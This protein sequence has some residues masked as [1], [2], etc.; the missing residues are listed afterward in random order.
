M[1]ARFYVQ[2]YLLTVPVFFLI[3]LVW[4]GLIAS[5]FY[6][7]QLG[8]LLADEVNWAAALVFYFSYIVGILA[9]ATLP[10]LHARSLT[11]TLA[12]AAGFGFFTYMTYELTNMATLPDWPLLI[13]VVDI[14]WGMALCTLV[15]GISYWI[16]TH[17]LARA[18]S[19]SR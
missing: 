11:R 9:F 8:H 17:L 16:G 5:D 15:A 18:E 2:L 19:V 6:A 4:L 13:V 3:D 12:R 1:N 10:G 7:A 14:A